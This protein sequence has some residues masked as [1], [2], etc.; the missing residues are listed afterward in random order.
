[1]RFWGLTISLVP[2]DH[3]LFYVSGRERD[4]TLIPLALLEIASKADEPNSLA[5]LRIG[6]VSQDQQD[7]IGLFARRITAH[8][9]D[10]DFQRHDQLTYPPRIWVWDHIEQTLL[11]QIDT[12]IFSDAEAAA[13][14]FADMLN[15]I[16]AKNQ[17]EAL[18][19][20][21]LLEQNFWNV[22]SEF[23]S[24]SEITFEYSTPNLFGK[25][26][27]E[28]RE[29]LS[30]IR[31]TTNATTLT[32]KIR[33]HEGNLHPKREGPI[34]RT[35]DWIKDGGGR[36]SMKGRLAAKDK[37]VTKLSGKQARVFA[38]PNGTIK[39]E[40]SGY[41]GSDLKKIIETLRSDY[42]FKRQEIS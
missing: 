11:V 9:Y 10:K 20:P 18:I 26:K 12:Q 19:Y 25:T 21:K 28:M 14:I 6:K 13:R 41:S 42:T 39:L 35:L 24:I 4:P 17:V 22:V 30:M 2:Q 7:L 16:L 5:R 37:L 8:L 27:E 23:R 29:F 33:N 40:T 1:M 36:W 3:D 34:A 31:N 32:T 38:L 15:P